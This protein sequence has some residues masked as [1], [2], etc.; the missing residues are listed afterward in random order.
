MLGDIIAHREGRVGDEAVEAELDGQWRQTYKCAHT[1]AW[2]NRSGLGT[3][4]F[5]DTH[6]KE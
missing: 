5:L 4:Y 1:S 6:L 3:L 2:R